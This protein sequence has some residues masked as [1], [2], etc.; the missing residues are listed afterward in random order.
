MMLSNL[1]LALTAV[2]RVGA[3]GSPPP[4]TPQAQFNTATNSQYV[5]VVLRHRYY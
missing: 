3:G 1:N 5:P 2:R 4:S